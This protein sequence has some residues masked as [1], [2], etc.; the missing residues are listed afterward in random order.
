MSCLA[1]TSAPCVGSHSTATFGRD[2]MDLA[3][4]TFCALPPDSDDTSSPMPP[5]RMAK[6]RTKPSAAALTI[7]RE[8]RPPR[9]NRPRAPRPTFSAMVNSRHTPLAFR[10][11]GRKATPAACA[12]RG[13]AN[14]ASRPHTHSEPSVS[15]L[16]PARVS[17]SSV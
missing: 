8:T 2:A 7:S 11:G 5:Q 14:D 9:Q 1:P 15:G 6:S 3:I 4:D 17:A 16:K 10:S 13:V 12:S